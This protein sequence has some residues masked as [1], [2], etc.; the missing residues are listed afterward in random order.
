MTVTTLPG[1]RTPLW[2][3]LQAHA[4]RL[5]D[6]SGRASCSS[7]TRAASSA[8]RASRLGCSWTTR[9]SGSTRSRLP[10]CCSWPMRSGCARAS[11]RCGAASTS[12]PPRAARCCTWRCGSRRARRSA[13]PDIEQTGHGRARSGCWRSP[14][15]CAAA[16][17]AAAAGRRFGLVVNIGI[18]GSD[19]GPAMAVQALRAYSAGAPR[20]EFVSN[21][22]GCHLAEVLEAADPGH[23]AVH[24]L[25]QDL[26]HA[27][28]ADQRA[29]RARLAGRPTRRAGRAAALRGGIGQHRRRWTSSAC[30]PQY[31]FQMWDWVGGRYSVWSSIGVSLAIAIGQQ[32]LPRLPRRRPCDGRAFPHRALERQ[33]AGAHGADRRCGTSTSSIC[34]HS[35]CC[36][37]TTR[38]GASRPT[39]S[40]SRWR[41]TAS[42]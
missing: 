10:S 29:H 31:R 42:R 16:P 27:R 38:C 5:A 21:I 14:K 41:A 35:P 19:L 18:G 13:A 17:S 7:A 37:T 28:D 25:L 36:R 26:H 20:C 6:R 32:Q 22:D 1:P 4:S 39:C 12:T 30:I 33:P 24:R 34:R 2:A 8:S 15:V 11:T 23:D 40:S 3:E 9:A